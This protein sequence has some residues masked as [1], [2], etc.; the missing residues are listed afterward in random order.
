MYNDVWSSFVAIW[1]S[2]LTSCLWRNCI[3]FRWSSTDVIFNDVQ[4][5][6]FCKR[7]FA[8][9]SYKRLIILSRS[10]SAVKC[11]DVLFSTFCMFVALLW[12]T[13]ALTVS[14]AYSDLGFLS[15]CCRVFRFAHATV[16]P[17]LLA[18]IVNDLCNSDRVLDCSFHSCWSLLGSLCAVPNTCSSPFEAVVMGL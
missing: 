14:V 15:L 2:I 8:S 3:T 11:S 1:I 17:L 4:F 5:S 7:T 10:A 18:L 13:S 12:S 9:C 6:L 16:R